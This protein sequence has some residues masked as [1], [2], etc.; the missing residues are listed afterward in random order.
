MAWGEKL[1]FVVTFFS[2]GNHERAGCVALSKHLLNITARLA[3]LYPDRQPTHHLVESWEPSQIPNKS[4]RYLKS[5]PFVLGTLISVSRLVQIV[6]ACV[7]SGNVYICTARRRHQAFRCH[8]RALFNYL[9]L[10][11]CSWMNYSCGITNKPYMYQV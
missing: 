11:S 10:G 9:M 1:Y 8:W 2:T 5:R 7:G 3:V 6:F 4:M